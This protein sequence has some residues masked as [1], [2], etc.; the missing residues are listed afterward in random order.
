MPGDLTAGLAAREVVA[1]EG[2]D[3][4]GKTTLATALAA[5]HGFSVVHSGRTPDGTDLAER[6]RAIL[7]TPGKIVL[8]RSF[9]SELVY[10]PL[11]HQRSRV[12][13]PD[14]ANLTRRVAA[15]GGVLA[16][17]TGNPVIIAAR[18]TA[19]DTDAPAIGQVRAITDACH[20]AFRM[21][22]G[23]APIITAD[24][25]TADRTPRRPRG[26]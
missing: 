17:L 1:L 19:R 20:S 12:T 22:E 23:T 3:G 5:N 13:L 25:T 24:T 11:L 2:C 7:A 15:R 16:H 26:S 10:G 4:T 14:A 21:L 18:L 8:D 6:Y 9:I